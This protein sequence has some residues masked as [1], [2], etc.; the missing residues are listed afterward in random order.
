M[1]LLLGQIVFIESYGDLAPLFLRDHLLSRMVIL[2]RSFRG[3]RS[4]GLVGCG[5][6]WRL[7]TFNFIQL[8]LVYNLQFAPLPCNDPRPARCRA[9]RGWGPP[10][11]WP[12]ALYSAEPWTLE[13]I[14]STACPCHLLGRHGPAGAES[15]CLPLCTP[16]PAARNP[17]SVWLA[18]L[19]PQTACLPVCMHCTLCRF[20]VCIC[21]C[22]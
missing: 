11:L 8:V 4:P 21:A 12:H 2:L 9:G 14:N 16:S 5:G 1:Y 3:L 15:D 6:A 13:A 18:R 20:C 19:R 7:S 10:V 17:A 22:V